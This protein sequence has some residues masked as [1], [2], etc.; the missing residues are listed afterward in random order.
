M[1]Q[2]EPDELVESHELARPEAGQAVVAQREAL[3]APRQVLGDVAEGAGLAVH[4]LPIAAAA[5]GA[6]PLAVGGGRRQPHLH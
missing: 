2:V 3:A 4:N 5:L 1:V 6:R